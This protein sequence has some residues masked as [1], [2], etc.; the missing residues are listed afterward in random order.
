MSDTPAP[1][2]LNGFPVI[3]S[4]VHPNGYV[5]VLVHRKSETHMPYVVATWTPVCANA[6]VWGHYCENPREAEDEFST[7]A[8]RNKARGPV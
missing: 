2:S 5:T 8:R 6:W 4:T 1:R 3:R 7:V